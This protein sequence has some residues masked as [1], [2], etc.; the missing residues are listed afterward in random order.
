MEL[1]ER[2]NIKVAKWLIKQSKSTLHEILKR[3]SEDPSTIDTKYNNLMNYLK[4]VIETNGVITRIYS[5]SSKSNN[6][7]GGR[8][9]STTVSIQNISKEFRGI[10]MSHTTDVDMSNAHPTILRYICSLHNIPCPQLEYYI[11]HRSEIYN[12]FEDK[13]KAKKIFLCSINDSKSY[14]SQKNKFYK[15][16]DK[17]MKFIQNELSK[18]EKYNNILNVLQNTTNINGKLVNRILCFYENIILQSAISFMNSRNIEIAVLMFDGIMIYGNYYEDTQLLIDLFEYCNSKFNNLN[19]QW[20]YKP[21]STVIQLPTDLDYIPPIPLSEEQIKKQNL[22]KMIEDLE[23]KL[24]KRVEEF[25]KNHCKIIN[26]GLYLHEYIDEYGH[27]V[28]ITLTPKQLEK[29]YEHLDIAFD[30]YGITQGKLMPRSFIHYWITA[31]PSIRNYTDMDIYPNTHD[32]P[33]N[34][35]NL[36]TPFY[37]DSLLIN[38]DIQINQ[39]HIDFFRNHLYIL[40]G[41]D[42]QVQKYFEMWIAHMIQSPE[43]KSTCPV[44]ISNEGSGKGSFTKTMSILMGGK[45]CFETTNPLRDVFG[46]FNGQMSDSFLVNINEIGKKDLADCMGYLKGIVTDPVLTINKKGIEPYKIKSFHRFIF[47]TN[48]SDPIDVKEGNRRFWIVRCSD[49]LKGNIE[50]FNKFHSLLNNLSF[51]KSVYSYFAFMNIEDFS[52]MDL[53]IG[54]YQKNIQESNV[55]D[56]EKWLKSYVLFYVNDTEKTILI[57]QLYLSFS[58]WCEEHK[59]KYVITHKKFSLELSNIQFKGIYKG[60]HTKHGDTK[61]LNITELKSYFGIGCLVDIDDTDDEEEI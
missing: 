14:K 27:P 24:N 32:C 30:R 42:T 60:S 34:I 25:E 16:F 39:E 50:Y 18:I 52:T 29:N 22:D 1:V 47:T 11:N 48:I 28:H 9:F 6:E 37:G 61:I 12:Q 33:P 43:Q 5:F 41:K 17:E 54:E 38:Q 56:V 51:L 10:L 13:E 26:K 40:S 7:L 53:P 57:K 8:L 36:W 3:K 35:Y 45:K 59:C 19:L 49:D 44:F 4:S 46:N 31:N 23:T 21:H 55:S 15:D 2:V 58:Q 20:N